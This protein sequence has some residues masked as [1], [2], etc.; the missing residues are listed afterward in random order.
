MTDTR[1]EITFPFLRYKVLSNYRQSLAW[2]EERSKEYIKALL[3]E[4]RHFDDGQEDVCVR[5]IVFR[6]GAGLEKPATLGRVMKQLE[7]SFYIS[8][9]CEVTL[10]VNHGEWDPSKLKS[11]AKIGISRVHVRFYTFSQAAATRLGCLYDPKAIEI[12]STWMDKVPEVLISGEFLYDYPGES[13]SEWVTTLDTITDMDFLHVRFTRLE[14]KPDAHPVPATE[15]ATKD[16]NAKKKR[17]KAKAAEATAD[18][19]A[20]NGTAGTTVVLDASTDSTAAGSAVGNAAAG[21]TD[22][23][24]GVAGAASRA[25]ASA[26]EE[27]ARA[28]EAE[29]HRNEAIGHCMLTCGYH[30]YL[31]MTFAQTYSESYDLR[32]AQDPDVEKL[33]FGMGAQTI[34]GGHRA[35]N[36]M[37]WD[38]YLKYSGN[39]AAI[40]VP[41]MPTG[42]LDASSFTSLEELTKALMNATIGK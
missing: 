8:D 18:A 25:N 24:S 31:P 34:M 19:P 1:I 32:L 3:K 42:I 4:I 23:A 40:S 9:D 5:S 12:L 28:K 17:K 29:R 20:D 27:E 39:Y 16:P 21:K 30:E 36:T 15:F 2:T 33:G 14:A 26:N 37:D 41:E 6:G 38:K 7:K 35:S 22:A 10:E 11:L 13:V